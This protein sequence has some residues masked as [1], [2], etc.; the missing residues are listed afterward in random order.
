MPTRAEIDRAKAL[1]EKL[2]V[3][4]VARGATAAEAETAATTAARICERYGLNMPSPDASTQM[5]AELEGSLCPAWV[6]CLALAIADRFQ[7]DS[8]Y[9]TARGERATVVFV[10]EEHLAS[11]ATWLFGAV[12]LDIRRR[13][14]WSAMAHDARGPARVKHRRLFSECAAWEVALRLSPPKVA[15]AREEGV[16]SETQPTKKRRGRVERLTESELA[17]VIGGARFGRECAVGT[18]AVGERA[19]ARIG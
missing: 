18:N 14:H 13:S 8:Y 16:G 4:T 5:G 7:C 19:V 11:V 2:R 17:A 3:R 9:T 15:P 1:L 12:Y 10:G 6:Y